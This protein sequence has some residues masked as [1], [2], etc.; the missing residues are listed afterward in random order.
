[1]KNLKNLEYA[2][3]EKLSR[4]ELAKVV[5][6]LAKNVNRNYNSVKNSPIEN[7]PATRGL[8]NSGGTIKTRGKN[9][10]EL[11]KEFIR[12]KKYTESKTGTVRNA[13]KV[14]NETKKRLNMPNLTSDDIKKIY[15]AYQDIKERNPVEVRNTGSSDIIKAIRDMYVQ[16]KLQD[17]KETL[18]EKMLDTIDKFYI[19][20]EEKR[21]KDVESYGDINSYANISNRPTISSRP[22]SPRRNRKK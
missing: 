8:D 10:N 4:N 5:Q 17:S 16:G 1:M 19:D 2:N 9:R 12:A 3:I 14:F 11:V 13:T 6:N 15:G 22:K 18:V 7:T 20:E 21:L